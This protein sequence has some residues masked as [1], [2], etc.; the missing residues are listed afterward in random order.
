MDAEPGPNL[1]LAVQG[2]CS[3]TLL[4]AE[5]NSEP[6]TAPQLSV[7]AEFVQV[8]VDTGLVLDTRLLRCRELVP[9]D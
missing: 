5:P 7:E 9:L 1:T 8:W 6:I 3:F 2:C 4:T